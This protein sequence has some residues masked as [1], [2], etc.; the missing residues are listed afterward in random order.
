DHHSQVPV[1]EES[2]GDRLRPLRCGGGR[3]EKD[4]PPVPAARQGDRWGRGGRAAHGH[5]AAAL[6]QPPGAGG[7]LSLRHRHRPHRVRQ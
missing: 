6:R 2:A 7:T 3:R 1:W 4:H 5:A